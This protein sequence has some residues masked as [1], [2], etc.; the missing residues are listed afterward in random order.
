MVLV[1]HLEIIVAERIQTPSP[2]QRTWTTWLSNGNRRIK[3]SQVLGASAV[4]KRAS[5]TKGPAVILSVFMS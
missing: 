3:D 2:L 4:S 5:K 1:A